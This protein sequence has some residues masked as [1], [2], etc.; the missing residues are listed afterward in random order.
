MLKN[1]TR[2]ATLPFVLFF[3]TALVYFPGCSSAFHAESEKHYTTEWSADRV[4]NI[5][6]FN[7]SVDVVADPA[8]TD[9]EIDVVFK[10]AGSNQAEAQ[11]RA[12]ASTLSMVPDDN[13]GLIIK[14]VVPERRRG[15]DGA[16]ITIHHPGSRELIVHT[17]NGP[18]RVRE[19]NGKCQLTTSNGPITL[20]KQTGA[21]VLETSNGNIN[22]VDIDGH[23]KAVTS[24]GVVSVEN[25]TSPADIKTSNGNITI[26]LVDGQ[27]GPLN[28]KTSNGSIHVNAGDGFTGIMRLSTSNGKAELIG[29]IPANTNVI[30]DSRSKKTI[31]I[32]D[33]DA[34]SVFTTSNG[35]VILEINK[36]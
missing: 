2:L 28:L 31:R 25:I 32:G 7:G 10:C 19:L 20:K 27:K 33:D 1:R 26:V 21:A 30:S 17:S 23:L 14:P 11:Q 3:L 12:D 36:E 29:D 24:N 34:E 6:S 16:S 5:D 8:L 35:N 18:I 13:R 15:N 4:L 22:V 9:M